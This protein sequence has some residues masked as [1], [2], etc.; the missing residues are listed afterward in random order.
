MKSKTRV[1]FAF[2]I[3]ALAVMACGGAG[4]VSQ[5]SPQA[6][7]GPLRIVADPS[8]GLLDA[9]ILSS[10]GVPYTVQYLGS[11]EMKLKVQ[12]YSQANPGDVDVFWSASP[13]WL[14]GSFVVN[15]T[16][17]MGSYVVFGVDPSVAAKFGWNIS[18]GI[19]VD[20][21]MQAANAHTLSL[22]MASS[23]QDDASANFYMAVLT[24]LK[25]TGEPLDGGDL[26]N[27]AITGPMKTFY[28]NVSRG[29]N[30]S[31]DLASMFVADQLSGKPQFNSFVL[32]EAMAI[33]VNRQLVAKNANPMLI[34]YV[35]DAV[36]L[37]SFTMGYTKDASKEKQQKFNSL[38]ACLTS[39]D[40]QKKLQSLGFRTGSVGMKIDNPDTTVFNTAWGIHGDVE[41]VTVNLPKP[42][43]IEAAL[44]LYQNEL[45][46]A[47]CTAYDL[48][49][50]PSMGDSSGKRL[51]IVA[52]NLLL[53]QAKASQ[54]LLQ[55]GPKDTTYAILFSDK[56]LAEYLVNG[57]DPNQLLDLYKAIERQGFG[58]GTNIYGSVIHGL[59][60]TAE[61][62]T[63]DQLPA[64]VLLTD[65]AHNIGP[66]YIDLKNYYD[67]S[68]N[69]VPVHAI[70][71]GDAV[72]EDL[73]KIVDL[74]NGKICDGRN[75]QDALVR[76]FRDIKGSN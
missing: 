38:V 22:A 70:M 27:P 75:G 13:T 59:Q 62:C 24:A 4:T 45:R 76:C 33:S 15:K 32:P 35:K 12:S 2:V 23:S 25:G 63:A 28:S 7:T 66:N 51:L 46:K 73:Q 19:S 43:V 14:P 69:K 50:S 57:N 17:I 16:P 71:M 36:G 65:G 21:V 61:N 52:M 3:L 64:V 67:Q 1:L 6:D 72:L 42:V 18:D 56:I 48:D 9:E 30:N 68:G 40:S 5:N 10:C 37:Q 39:S 47:S 55:T 44:N 31:G 54:Y 60:V 11:V 74:T 58:N 26:V 49:F 20:K 53:D 8:V 41:Y 29:S 34:F